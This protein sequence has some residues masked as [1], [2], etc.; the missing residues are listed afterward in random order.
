MKK[1]ICLMLTFA[2]SFSLASCSTQKVQEEIKTVIP[3]T[4]LIPPK[5]EM[6]EHSEEFKDENGRVVYTVNVSIPQITDNA[7][8]LIKNYINEMSLDIFNEA[9]KNAES[10]IKNAASFMDSGNRDTPWSK[11]ITV[12]ITHSDGRYLSLLISENFSM[13]GGSVEPTLRT[14]CYD[15]LN[16][17]PC[18]LYDFVV[19]P[20]LPEDAVRI[21]VDDLLCDEISRL[22][23]NG[24]PLTQEQIDIAHEAFD[25]RNFYLF[26][27][28]IGFCISKS[29]FDQSLSGSLKI[30]CRWNDIDYILRMPE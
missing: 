10:N 22:M 13:L 29:A 16:G 5:I 17:V 2:L 18:T 20:T 15:L 27:G 14:A 26:D 8:E 6:V 3:T 28:G 19:E 25:D 12:D 21:I 30:N 11:D 1:F 7:T 24:E 9:C 23:F 4:T